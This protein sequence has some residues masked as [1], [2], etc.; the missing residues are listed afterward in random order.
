MLVVGLTGGIAS[1]KTTVGRLFEQ[2]GIPII[3]A[4]DLAKKAV[5]PG[6]PALELIR[7][8]FGETV[9]DSSGEL[10]RAAMAKVVFSDSA[11]RKML[12]T[13]IHPVVSSEKELRLRELQQSGFEIAIVDVPLLYEA[14]WEKSFDAVIVVFVQRDIQES[15]LANRDHFSQDEVKS[16]LDSQ[17]SLREKSKRANFLIDNSG[18]LDNTRD[19]VSRIVEVLKKMA[20]DDVHQE[21]S[22]SKGKID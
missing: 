10:D 3:C 22:C 16:R 1:G 21:Q 7:Q 14:G 4:D 13:I 18:H 20:R 17:M 6:S 5:S 15:R 8:E 12:E 19:Q 11:K 9:I 2:L